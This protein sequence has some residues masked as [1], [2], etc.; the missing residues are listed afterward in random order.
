MVT[1]ASGFIGG[2][3]AS[4][5]L[6]EGHIVTALEHSQ[7]VRVRGAR[8]VHANVTVPHEVDHAIEGADIVVHCAAKM[9]VGTDRGALHS[10]NV[11]GTKN[12]FES[13]SRS[14][15]RQIVHLS[16]TCVMNEYEDHEMTDETYPYPDGDLDSY[17]L[18]K[19]EAERIAKRYQK[20]LGVAIMRPGWVW[21]PGSNEMVRLCKALESG[22][23]AIPGS[24]TNALHLIYVDNVVHAV[25]LA[26]TRSAKGVF[27]LTDGSNVTL[28]QFINTLSEK[29]GVNHSFLHIP[30]GICFRAARLS[31]AIGK[32]INLTLPTRL[33]IANLGKDHRYDTERSRRSLE[34]SPRVTFKD[35]VEQTVSWYKGWRK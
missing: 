24:G 18:S 35:G 16:S 21:G 31:E 25:D 6:S 3:I 20:K 7:R 33:E 22:L 10:T 9:R 13:S 15:V 34:Y 1:G 11:L 2:A 32:T 19:I 12:V 14:G 27:I 29:L 4:H 5:L 30:Y 17:T 28:E 26:I 23:F 8:I